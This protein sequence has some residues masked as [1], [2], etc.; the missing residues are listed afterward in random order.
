M[1]LAQR[2]LPPAQ[3][4]RQV[5][6]MMAQSLARTRS[7][8]P[9]HN[10]RR[11]NR[12]RLRISTTWGPARVPR[13][14]QSSSIICTPQ[15]RY[16]PSIWP[17]RTCIPGLQAC[18]IRSTNS[19]TT[20]IQ[21]LARQCSLCSPVTCTVL[22]SGIL[23][24]MAIAKPPSTL[25]LLQARPTGDRWSTFRTRPNQR[26]LCRGPAQTSLPP[27]LV[28]GCR[29]SSGH[30]SLARMRRGVPGTASRA[31]VLA[32]PS[33]G[34]LTIAVLQAPNP[35]VPGTVPGLKRGGTTPL[36]LPR[37]TWK[38]HG[39]RFRVIPYAIMEKLQCVRRRT[40]TART[41]S[42]QGSGLYF[43]H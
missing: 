41:V 13:C 5:A 39:C 10:I 1:L 34:R 12:R 6:G 2:V 14:P 15:S 32:T 31:G 36:G 3:C 7:F 18:I 33:V 38:G 37:L 30:R 40:R 26:T 25:T 24:C 27:R 20:C 11:C 35:T 17:L 4:T 19:C 29:I 21:C 22:A 8:R 16:R 42:R 23:L 9:Y 28:S 43:E